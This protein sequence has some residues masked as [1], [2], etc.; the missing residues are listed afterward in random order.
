VHDRAF[1]VRNERDEVYRI[2]G[3]TEDI[4][5]HKRAEQ[6]LEAQRDVGVALSVTNDLNAA[7]ERL[8]QTATNLEGIDC[9][10]VYLMNPETGALE[11]EA[12]S[13]L[14]P[15]FVQRVAR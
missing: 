4:T 6:L 1:P 7:L 2:V 11:L 13:G 3:I 9:G 14:S 8:L 5:E 12:H 15:E 10:G